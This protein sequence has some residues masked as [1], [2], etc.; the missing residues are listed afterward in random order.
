MRKPI[1]R[2]QPRVAAFQ[3]EQH[4]PAGGQTRFYV[5]PTLESDFGNW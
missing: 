3:I 4:K 5:P 1:D 2:H